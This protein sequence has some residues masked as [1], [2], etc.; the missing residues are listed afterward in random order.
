[1]HKGR[2]NLFVSYL[3]II[4]IAVALGALIF[5]LWKLN[6]VRWH[7]TKESQVLEEQIS[8]RQQRRLELT[9][10]LDML[11]TEAFREREAKERLGLAKPGE[12]VFVLLGK[13]EADQSS[14]AEK[15]FKLDASLLDKQPPVQ[16]LPN[17]AKW[18]L[19]LS[20]VKL[21]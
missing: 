3:S 18:L 12:E 1:M 17:P 5:A 16:H 4:A 15:E 11:D 13:L 6:N 2:T 7:I 19:Y 14:R 10:L 20:G 9:R 8:S 21:D